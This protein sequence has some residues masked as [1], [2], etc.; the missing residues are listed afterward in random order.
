VPEPP[1]AGL[2]AFDAARSGLLFGR[3]AHVDALVER[4][5]S[6]RVLLLRG[7]SG[8]GK[9]S[10]AVAGVAARV[11]E[12]M[13]DG[14]DGWRTLV[15]RPSTP[16]A[17]VLGEPT[18]EPIAPSR[19]GTVVVVD[20]LEETLGL[21]EQARSAFAA[22]LEV[23]ASGSAPVSIAGELI[24][25]SD[26]VRVLATVRDDLE[27]QV[28]RMGGLR[29]VFD[30]HR[31]YVVGIDAAA[32]R[33]IV[34]QP[35]KAAGAAVENIE[36]V[37]A[38]VREQLANQATILPMVQ[39]ALTEWWRRRDCDSS[40]P[41]L[42]TAEWKAIGG[43]R[44]ALAHVAEGFYERLEPAE[45]D[46]AT[47]SSR[48]HSARS[49]MMPRSACLR[50]SGN[51]GWYASSSGKTSS[52][53]RRT[54]PRALPAGAPAHRGRSG[55]R[56][57]TKRSP[58]SGSACRRGSARPPRTTPSSTS[59]SSPPSSGARRA[60]PS[61]W[62]FRATSSSAR[63]IW[64]AASTAR[65]RRTSPPLPAT[66]MSSSWRGHSRTSGAAGRASAS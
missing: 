53:V 15:V 36:V 1:Y 34:E 63:K 48:L 29:Q 14:T 43:V 37:A 52:L 51:I 42:T 32:A 10:L 21:D 40:P 47:A 26:Q 44:G 33:E 13:L 5:R 54:T 3:R 41:L 62:S 30:R 2:E 7:P 57:R 35:A 11:D 4:L 22:A 6:E 8:C 9:S 49:A 38:E 55:T 20:Q 65:R 45:R 18:S 12:L 19:L 27:W 28:V 56:Q 59:S 25:P 61:A 17:L 46:A 58:A 31:E 50:A 39:F 60:A 23:L 66:R 24:E 64:P 16:D